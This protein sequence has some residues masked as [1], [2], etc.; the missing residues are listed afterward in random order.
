MREFLGRKLQVGDKSPLLHTLGKECLKPGHLLNITEVG[1]QEF[2]S[3]EDI[4][5]LDPAR[6]IHLVA[7]LLAWL[8]NINIPHRDGLMEF[9]DVMHCSPAYNDHDLEKIVGV[10]V[11]V[12]A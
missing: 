2:L 4:Y 7:V 8:D 1:A 6:A 10:R 5:Y 12:P 3:E 11:A 9:A